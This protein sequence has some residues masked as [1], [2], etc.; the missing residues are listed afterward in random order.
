[1][2]GIQSGVILG[3]LAIAVLAVLVV[4]LFAPVRIDLWLL[5]LPLCIATVWIVDPRFAIPLGSAFSV[6][7]VAGLFLSSPDMAFGWALSN[8]LL[9]LV[10]LWLTVLLGRIF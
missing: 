1:M 4:D 10:S 9:A 7:I 5:Y 8:R 6:L 3:V 2:K